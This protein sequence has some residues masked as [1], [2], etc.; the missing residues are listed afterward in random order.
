MA[1]RAAAAVAGRDGRIHLDRLE[2]MHR[3]AAGSL[4]GVATD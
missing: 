4:L 2:R 3:D 1:A